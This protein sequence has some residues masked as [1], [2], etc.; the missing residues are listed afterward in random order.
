[1]GNRNAPYQINGP[2]FCLSSVISVVVASA[3]EAE[4]A[5]IFMNAQ[6]AA[7]H[8]IIRM[9]SVTHSLRRSFF[10]TTLQPSDSATKPSSPNEL[11]LWTC[12]FTGYKTALLKDSSQCNI[13]KENTSSPL[14]QPNSPTQPKPNAV[15]RSPLP[16]SSSQ[17][18]INTARVTAAPPARIS[19]STKARNKRRLL[20]QINHALVVHDTI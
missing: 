14:T 1:M 4:Y 17:F 13:E 9:P 10:L 2:F 12:G 6:A 20:R 7:F 3:A 5:A 19:Q 8:R 15:L 16:T 11:K 18:C